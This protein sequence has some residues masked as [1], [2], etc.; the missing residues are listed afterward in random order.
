MLIQSTRRPHLEKTAPSAGPSIASTQEQEAP[1][2]PADKDAGVLVGSA[3]DRIAHFMRGVTQESLQHL[4]YLS[5]ANAFQKVGSTVG[6]LALTP[7]AIKVA[8]NNA[9]LIGGLA[10]GG[11]IAAGAIGAAVGYAWLYRR[12]GKEDDNKLKEFSKV[13]D[14]ALTVGTALQSLP[15]FVYPSIVGGTDAQVETI[16]NALDK[17]PLHQATASSTMQIV[18]GLIGTGISGMS[19]PGDSHVHILLDESYID[20]KWS[21]E[22]LVMHEQAH[23]VDYSGGFGLL[24]AH[25]WKAGFGKEP[26]VSGYASSNRYEDFAESFEAYQQDPESFRQNFPAKAAAIEEISHADP[27]SAAADQPGVRKAGRNIGATLGKVPYLRTG[28]ELAGSLVAPIQAHRGASKLIEG[29]ETGNKAQQLDGKLNLATGLFLSIPGAR[30][31]ALG[32]GIAGNAIRLTSREDNEEHMDEANKWANRVLSVSAGPVGMA[33]GAIVGEMQAN[34]LKI[35]ESK[36]FTA[37][38]WQSSRPGKGAMLK[39]TLATVGGTVGGALLGAAI[40]G[41]I[42]GSPGAFLG[43]LWG[44]VAGGMTG[45]AGYSVHRTLKNSKEDDPMALTGSDKRFLGRT[46][47]GAVVG[48]GAGTVAGAIGGRAVGELLG[49]AVGSPSTAS[50]LGSVG[51]W[52]GGLSLAYGGAKL[53]AGLGSGRLLGNS[54][55][56]PK[57]PGED[58]SID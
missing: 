56:D 33:V 4:R 55:I 8:S 53:G 7:L 14:T 5:A 51:G 50:F 42:S 21:A 13:T 41:A 16:Y 48:A 43:A 28:L 44:Q 12:D 25:N 18:P 23:A 20:S 17:L 29:L 40:G 31:F 35:D 37:D 22:N 2:P 57:K 58:Q 24:G 9:P 45:L 47:G 19:Q 11:T 49:N 15:K 26:F 39:G 6:S 46:L 36:G 3:G 1:A 52:L 10:I 54:P 38:G 34:G 30:P 32:S 27:L